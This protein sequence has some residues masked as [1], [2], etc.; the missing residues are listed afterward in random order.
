MS[1]D[2]SGLSAY[3]DEQS[4]ELIGRLYFENTSSQYF[5]LETGIKSS[6]A[7]QLISVTAVPQDESSC[8]FNASGTTTLTQRNITVGA[9]KYQD[10]LCPKDLRAKWTQI[11]LRPGSTGDSD[12]IPFEQVIADMI[13]MQIKEDTETLDWQG[14]TAHGSAYLNKYD[15]LIKLI[16]AAGTAIDGNTGSLAS[17][18]YGSSGNA[19]TLVENMILARPTEL[20]RQPNQV[21]FCG[22]DFFDGYVKTWIATN[23]YWVDATEY[24]DYTFSIPG[25]NVTLVGVPG[26]DTTNRLFLGKADNFYLGV[27]LS[28]EDERFRMWYSWDDDNVKYDVRFKRGV[29]VAYPSEIV[30]FTLA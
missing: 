2:L 27:D 10:T 3:T 11:M 8:G 7:I 21:L 17:I 25:Y 15:G 16:D 9:V 22:T 1:F 18:T 23:N 20:K 29:Q 5:S 19:V 28:G 24:A 12:N 30:E 13:I 4:R 6:K 26:L 14:N